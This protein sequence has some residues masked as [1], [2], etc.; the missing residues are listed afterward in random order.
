MLQSPI[1]PLYT[2]IPSKTIT[3]ELNTESRGSPAYKV[4]HKNKKYNSQPKNKCAK[5][6]QYYI[7]GI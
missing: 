2:H 3:A 1:I 4:K 6:L 7:A 5:Q